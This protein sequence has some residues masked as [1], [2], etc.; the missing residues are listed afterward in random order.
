MLALP[1]QKV[2]PL[3]LITVKSG[4]EELGPGQKMLVEEGGWE[5]LVCLWWTECLM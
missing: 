2:D 5:Y 1:D 3:I 4:R